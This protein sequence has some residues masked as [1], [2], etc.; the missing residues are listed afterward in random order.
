LGLKCAC[1][2]GRRWTRSSRAPTRPLGDA[3]AWGRKGLSTEI[4]PLVAVSLA[5]WGHATRAHLH[6]RVP[7]IDLGARYDPG[8]GPHCPEVVARTRPSPSPARSPMLGGPHP[9][10]RPPKERS[11]LCRR[12]IAL[13]EPNRD[14][15]FCGKRPR[16][17]K[18][19]GPH[20]DRAGSG[21]NNPVHGAD[22]HPW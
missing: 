19:P 16:G 22:G 11:R 5:R 17:K 18:A 8:D 4:T 21:E 10:H 20:P 6:N 13:W 15:G 7:S 12:Y 1:A 9:N 3:W 14:G 2:P